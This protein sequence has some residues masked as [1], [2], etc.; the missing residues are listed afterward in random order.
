MAARLRAAGFAEKDVVVMGPNPRKGNL[1][2]RIHGTSMAK[3]ILLLGHLDVVEARREDWTTN[4]FE[5]VEK[6]GYFYGRGTVDMKDGAAILV[7]DFIRLKREGVIP[8]R[9]LI[10]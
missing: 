8:Q 1:I 6:D 5:F 3:P 2:A 4:P 10:L 7:A 9:D